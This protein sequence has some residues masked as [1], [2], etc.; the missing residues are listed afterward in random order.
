MSQCPYCAYLS[1]VWIERTLISVLPT[2]NLVD[3]ARARSRPLIVG[4]YPAS[5]KHSRLKLPCF[6]GLIINTALQG[7]YIYIGGLVFMLLCHI[8]YRP[9][10][11]LL[12]C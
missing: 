3:T 7:V 4:H 6:A 9:V 11:F 2:I 10:I 8:S 5:W 12:N 1:R